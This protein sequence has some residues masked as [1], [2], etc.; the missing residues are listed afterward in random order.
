MK[1]DKI[2]N[3]GR[4]LPIGFRVCVRETAISV[5]MGTSPHTPKHL[6]EYRKPNH[7]HGL[8]RDPHTYHK[9][10]QQKPLASRAEQKSKLEPRF[11]E[12]KHENPYIPL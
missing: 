12:A 5:R 3:H 7:L 8:K 6:S 10:T 11:C 4:D 9:G 1:P 2:P